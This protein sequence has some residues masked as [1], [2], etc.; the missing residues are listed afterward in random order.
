MSRYTPQAA[1][2]S[3][4]RGAPLKPIC[5]K[6]SLLRHFSFL[7]EPGTDCGRGF[8]VKKGRMERVLSVYPNTGNLLRPAFLSLATLTTPSI[9]HA[10]CASS[11]TYA[12]AHPVSGQPVA[13]TFNVGYAPGFIPPIGA[14]TEELWSWTSISGANYQNSPTGLTF[15]VPASLS[16]T[17]APSVAGPFTVDAAYLQQYAPGIPPACPN[18][19][20]DS[21]VSLLVA[22]SG[23]A[24]ANPQALA[25]Q[26]T[27][28]FQGSLSGV[29]ATNK[30]IAMGSFTADGKGNITTGVEDINLASGSRQAMPIL[31]GTYTVD[32]S[33]GSLILNTASGQQQF[34][35]FASSYATPNSTS[36]IAS[37]SLVYTGNDPLGTGSLVKQTCYVPSGAYVMNWQGAP[38]AAAGAAYSLTPAYVTG[39]VN[40]SN[41]AVQAYL[42]IASAESGLLKGIY[43]SGIFQ[44]G[45]ANGRFTYTL[46]AEGS[47]HQ[48]VNFVGYAVDATHF[49]T[50]SLDD[51]QST[52]LFSGTAM[53]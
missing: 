24:P 32:G 12:P 33:T 23:T 35:L 8:S 15:T 47:L 43:E 26:Y 48:P 30:V 16:F 7:Y 36:A 18:G 38:P 27:F 29:V 45:D 49:N 9:L 3:D 46:N 51:Y 40:F 1:I 42:D 28:Q 19:S 44:P 39:L 13:F 21:M 25:G 41:G 10:Q 50:M 37:A 2:D 31:S 4:L 17:V 6:Q 53:Q 20:G 34:D 22:P 52:F 14:D 11:L 5:N